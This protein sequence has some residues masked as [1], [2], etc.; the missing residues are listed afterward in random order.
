MSLE[1]LRTL[2][3]LREVGRLAGYNAR[4]QITPSITFTCDGWIT[5]W[6]IGI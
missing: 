4:Q 6:I 5:K 3:G 1:T 2:V